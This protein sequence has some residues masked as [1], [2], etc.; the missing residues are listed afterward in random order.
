MRNISFS[1]TLDSF[2]NGTKDVTRRL[3]WKFLKPGDH[4]CA[5]EKAQGLKK[6]QK[7]KKIG[8]IVVVSTCIEQ[9]R[10]IEYS[11]YRDDDTHTKGIRSEMLREGFPKFT[12]GQF[13]DMFCKFNR[14]TPV[15]HVNRIVFLRVK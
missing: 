10:C 4:L 14:C 11:S 6:G 9:L 8:E 3:G 7:I 15:S 12:A 1:V 5:V 13:I 2:H